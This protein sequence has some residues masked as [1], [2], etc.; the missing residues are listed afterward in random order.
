MG[1]ESYPRSSQNRD[2]LKGAFSICVFAPWEKAN[3]FAFVRTR[4]SQRCASLS[5]AKGEHRETGSREIFVRKFTCERVLPAELAKSRRPER[6]V[7]D[8]RV[9]SAG[10][11]KLLC[12]R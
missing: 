2:A 3:F 4:K 9:R 12:F 5:G 11:S 6:G 7:F 1:F 8:L 10:E